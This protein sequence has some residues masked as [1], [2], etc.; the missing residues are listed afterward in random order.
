[1]AIILRTPLRARPSTAPSPTAPQPITAAMLSSVAPERSEACPP[2][3]S[4]SMRAIS[5]CFMASASKSLVHGTTM[6][7]VSAPSR[8][9]PRVW[10][11]WQQLG[12]S[13]RQLGQTPQLVYGETVTFCP[14][15]QQSGTPGPFAS[16][17][18]LIS[19]PGIRGRVMSG[20]LPRKVLRSLPQ[21][22]TNLTASRTLPGVSSGSGIS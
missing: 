3:V 6:C 1:M 19:W 18:A 2:T 17:T 10:L 15:R 14:T 12:R 20:F 22:P 9:T 8:C 5:S 7:F 16:I 4:G 11:N 13:A 21:R